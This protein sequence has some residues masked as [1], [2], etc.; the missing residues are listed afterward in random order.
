MKIKLQLSKEEVYLL[1]DF[2]DLGAEALVKTP[3]LNVYGAVATANKVKEQ[4]ISGD[5]SE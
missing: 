5:K 3:N 1:L 2:I 4:I